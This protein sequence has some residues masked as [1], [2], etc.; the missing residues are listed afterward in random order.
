MEENCLSNRCN[1]PFLTPPFPYTKL[2]FHKSSAFA[3]DLKDR[4]EKKEIGKCCLYPNNMQYTECTG[5]L[6]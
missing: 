5:S 3:A 6:P 1:F 4:T 2:V